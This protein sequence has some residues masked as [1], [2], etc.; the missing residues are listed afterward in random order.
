M[1]ILQKLII[2]IFFIKFFDSSQSFKKLT[3]L[4]DQVL[5]SAFLDVI[6][7]LF[8]T[9]EYQFNI[10]VYGNAS[11]HIKDVINGLGR[12]GFVFNITYFNNIR[13]KKKINWNFS[14]VILCE[15][16]E[17]IKNFLKYNLLGRKYFPTHF[18]FLFYAEKPFQVPKI[19]VQRLSSEF[20][21][22]G[23]YS[24]FIVRQNRKF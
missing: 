14:A 3:K 20:G 17:E 7:E 16:L 1:K 2:L 21:V 12:G 19:G 18:A 15:S 24:Y 10:I 13:R 22:I 11:P 9:R 6:Q 4:D 23:W 8:L 5:S